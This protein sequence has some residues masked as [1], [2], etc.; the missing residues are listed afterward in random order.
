MSS[1]S[2]QVLA[3]SIF[4]QIPHNYK[5]I[6]RRFDD[7][8]PGSFSRPFGAIMFFLIKSWPASL[9]LKGPES[10]NRVF[11]ARRRFERALFIFRRAL[12]FPVKSVN[13]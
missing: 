5:F 1:A 11:F 9:S 7:S 8:S 10:C 2:G 6:F 4:R 3:L 13:W 12:I